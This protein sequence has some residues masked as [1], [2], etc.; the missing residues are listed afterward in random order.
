MN[1]AASGKYLYSPA[2]LGIVPSTGL[3]LIE[4]SRGSLHV[5]ADLDGDGKLNDPVK[6]EIDALGMKWSSTFWGST[7]WSSL[8][9]QSSG[10]DSTSWSSTSWSGTSWSS[11]SWSSTSW[12][13]LTWS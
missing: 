4:A 7:S 13:S 1:A 5:N 10:W 2:N 8:T 12:S 3:G 9:S 11:T 6:G